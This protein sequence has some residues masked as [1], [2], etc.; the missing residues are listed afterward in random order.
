MTATALKTQPEGLMEPQLTVN[1]LKVLEK[2]YI[3]RDGNTPLES[4]GGRLW[5]VAYDLA[6]GSEHWGQDR[7]LV[8]QCYYHLMAKGD[9]MP[10]SPALMNAGK[11]NGL[12]Y[13]ACY[14]LP[15]GDS[16]DEIF[17]SVKRAAL[18]HKS[19][20]GTGF[21]FSRLRPAGD[22]VGTTGGIASGPV[23]F[24]EVFNGATEQVKQ[25][26]TRR[27]AN[28]G[29]LRVDH[30]DIMNWINCKR[31]LHGPMKD[32]YDDVAPGLNE[33]QREA[34]RRS[35]LERQISNF[36]ISVAIT[37]RFMDA[38]DNGDLFPLVH[39]VSGETA[40]WVNPMDI[41][42]EIC[43]AAWETGD[44]G[45]I[46]I[47]RINN[48]PSNPTPTLYQIESTNPCGEQ[49][50]E[51]NGVCNLGSINLG[52]FV[53]DGKVNWVRLESVTRL[54]TR[55]MDDVITVNPY[56]DD[57]IK[58]AAY[59]TR[60]LGLGVMGWADM[61]IRLGIPYDSQ[62][63]IDLAEQVMKRVNEWSH[64][65]SEQLAE[66]REP[67]PNFKDSIYASGRPIRNG[68]LT[69]VAPTGTIS[70]IAGCSS[71]IEPLFALVFDRK[72]SLDG[73]L[74][75][76]VN[77]D[78]VDVAKRE[79]FWTEELGERLHR[80][81]TVR[82]LDGVPE[83][84][85]RVFGTAHDI[86]PEWHIRM[87]AAWQ[88]Y[89]DNSISKTINLPHT[90]EVTDVDA[91]YKMAWDT[92]CKGTTVYRDGSKVGVLHV[93]N[94]EPEKPAE[95][96]PAVILVQD[97]AG[98]LNHVPVAAPSKNGH[99]TKF[100]PG[101]L[102]ADV[103]VPAQISQRPPILTGQTHSL[104]THLGTA[105][106]TI[107]EDSDGAP[108]EVFVNQGK[109]G[110]DLSPMAEAIGKLTSMLLRVPSTMSPEARLREVV[111]RL[112]GIGGSSS[113]GFGPDRTRS[114][115]D[116]LARALEAYLEN[117]TR[118]AVQEARDWLN[119]NDYTYL[120]PEVVEH[121]SHDLCPDCGN[122]LMEEEGC[123]KCHQCGF[124]RC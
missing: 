38:K 49:A 17:E 89:I 123:A 124:A 68:T 47:D 6:Q 42:S 122:A 105:Y 90:A 118:V 34:L 77:Q 69:T 23:S 29:I 120:E 33:T 13:S 59:A 75:L 48:S 4:P 111:R 8:A 73:A 45:L 71:G 109:A 5:A 16:M 88:K 96:A 24:M 36:N 56:P 84:W 93:G 15:V 82:G 86:H 11:D 2:R 19:G 43:D 35:L 9:F 52:N 112:R 22:F 27:G 18:V 117:P 95:A 116:A 114:L 115:P 31:Y 64:D 79:G 55:L 70:I 25:G 103:P 104:E 3:K 110:S 30:P 76:E 54:S 37:D 21:S 39:P 102:A 98:E 44:P 100:V 28:M 113:V 51:P 50:L 58:N 108:Y 85:Q 121:R 1:G 101:P 10:N 78:F 20:G 92:G 67:F 7:M 91:A 46:F 61:L 12:Q 83:K 107:N 63:A 32:A 72:G 97:K 65:E 119:S 14:V 41:W 66:E 74:S 53:V 60:R 94:G 81:G 106:I 80:Q 62:E 57:L 40:K 26:G 87:Q 99:A